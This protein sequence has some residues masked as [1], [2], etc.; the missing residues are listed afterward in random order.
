MKPLRFAAVQKRHNSTKIRLLRN[1]RGCH[2]SHI[3]QEN[4]VKMIYF[5]INGWVAAAFTV[6]VPLSAAFE[7]PSR[8]PGPDRRQEI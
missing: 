7:P 5:R 1:T 6:A 2:L 4:R 8:L 3:N